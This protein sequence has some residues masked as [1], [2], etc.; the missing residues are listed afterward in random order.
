[1]S[2]TNTENLKE[3]LGEA[4]SHLKSAA[5]AA[6][7]AIKGATGAL[8]TNCVSARPTSRP[9]CPTP[10]CRAWL[11]PSSVVPPPRNRWMP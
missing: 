4:G 9:S 5:T 3:H 6:G 7:G 8:A 10:R 1:M 2:P 11:P